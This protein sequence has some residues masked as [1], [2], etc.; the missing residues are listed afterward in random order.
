MRRL[1]IL[2][3]AIF[4]L[5]YGVTANQAQADSTEINLD[6]LRSCQFNSEL[7]V[8]GLELG[9]VVINLESGRGCADNQDRVFP[10]ASVPKLFVLGAYLEEVALGWRDP[11]TTIVFTEDYVMGGSQDCLSYDDVGSEVT[12]SF[13][14]DIMISCS[15]NSATW[16]LMDL[17]GWDMIQ[18]YVDGLGIEGIGPIIPYAEVDRL[19]LSMLDPDWANVPLSL[20]SQYYRNGNTKGLVPDYF[21]TRPRYSRRERLRA[22]TQYFA[23]YDYNTISPRAMTEY[24]LLMRQRLISSNLVDGLAAWWF[25][26]SMLLTQRQYTTQDL[27]GTIYLGAKNGY[28]YGLKAEVSV[29]TRDLNTSN[30]EAIAIIFVHQADLSAGDVGLPRRETDLLNRYLTSISPQVAWVLYPD[31]PAPPISASSNI[32]S[33]TFARENTIEN[34]REDA[35]GETASAFLR[36]VA[37]CWRSLP[38]LSRLPV[39]ERLGLGIVLREIGNRETRL[40]MIFVSPA[41]RQYSY[42]YNTRFVQEDNV[43]WFHRLDVVGEW[44]IEIYQDLELVYSDIIEAF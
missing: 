43:Y 3:L 28:D 33:V 13:L 15:D 30:P 24:L 21:R 19:K 4:G 34:C 38:T 20:A 31:N 36:A 41:G 39:G 32:V 27:P 42:Q 2:L 40:T 23:T 7:E 9:A 10:V 22:N 1:I 11:N 17:I 14:A 25:F 5:S 12:Y 18:A 8:S 44:R 37:E 26:Q 35:N 6:A 29:A 16:I